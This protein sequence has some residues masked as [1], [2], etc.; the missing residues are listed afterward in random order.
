ML[1][2]RRMFMASQASG[3]ATCIADI[4]PG[5]AIFYGPGNEAASGMDCCGDKPDADPAVTQRPDDAGDEDLT[6]DP[7]KVTP[8]GR[9]ARDRCPTCFQIPATNGACGCDY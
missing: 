2:T 6:V 3:C 9:T 5:D 7:R 8:R 4:L 1:T